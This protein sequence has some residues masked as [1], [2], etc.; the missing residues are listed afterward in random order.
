MSTTANYSEAQGVAEK[1][2][3]IAMEHEHG[4]A[5]L[6]HVLCALIEFDEVKKYFAE[7]AFKTSPA[8]A[9]NTPKCLANLPLLAEM[10]LNQLQI[11][12]VYQSNLCTFEQRE[13]FYSYRRAAQTGRIATL[14]WFS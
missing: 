3:Q 12:S 14:I 7:S 6:E 1:A 5:T 4:I 9:Q 13:K 2:I 10:I 8:S 11:S